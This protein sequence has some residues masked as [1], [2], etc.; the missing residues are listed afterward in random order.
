AIGYKFF[1]ASVT[2]ANRKQEKIID[3]STLLQ[4]YRFYFERTIFKNAHLKTVGCLSG[5]K[6]MDR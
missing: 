2:P 3:N 4:S 5:K 1:A 6:Y